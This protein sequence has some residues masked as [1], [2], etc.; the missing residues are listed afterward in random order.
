MFNLFKKE[1]WIVVATFE[2]KCYID[3]SNLFNWYDTIY[4]IIYIHC[5]ESENGKRKL[6]FTC[7][8][9]QSV[10]KKALRKSSMATEIY[11][12]RLYA[13]LSGRKDPE[14]SA[15]S[16]VGEDDIVNYLCRKV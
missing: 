10:K 1:K 15:Y 8:L 11:N 6:D 5:L 3:S 13:W 14:I 7:S 4:G 2:H 16:Q 9:E 12:N